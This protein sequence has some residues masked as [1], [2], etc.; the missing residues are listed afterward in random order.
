MPAIHVPAHALPSTEHL[1]ERLAKYT[2]DRDRIA[3]MITINPKVAGVLLDR[4]LEASVLATVFG[5]PR[6]V[7][8]SFL[9]AAFDAGMA[10]FAL[11]VEAGEV[12][13]VLGGAE[14]RVKATGPIGT[15]HPATWQRLFGLSL[16]LR[17]SAATDALSR[18]DVDLLRVA[19]TSM[20]EYRFDVVKAL[21]ALWRGEDWREAAA[22]ASSGARLSSYAHGAVDLAQ[23]GMLAPLDAR[24]AAAFDAALAAALEAQKAYWGSDEWSAHVIGLLATTPLGLAALAH[25]RGMPIGVESE[26]IPAWLVRGEL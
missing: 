14:H 11:A 5:H 16:A 3:E 26:Y 22:R 19:Q 7:S 13:V 24:N 25:D 15:I 18:L 6:S 12:T 8:R 10:A 2:R 21:Q 17:R 9:E 23:L 4:F 20:D 1:D